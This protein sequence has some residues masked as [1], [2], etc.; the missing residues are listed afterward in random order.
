ML[1]DDVRKVPGHLSTK[2]IGNQFLIVQLGD[3]LELGTLPVYRYPEQLC[4]SLHLR[5]KMN[6][7]IKTKTNAPFIIGNPRMAGHFPFQLLI[8]QIC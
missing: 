8:I 3:R 5:R 2:F 6:I 1:F 4:F 7:V